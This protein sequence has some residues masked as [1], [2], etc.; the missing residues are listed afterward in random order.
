MMKKIISV[1]LCLW[2]FASCD[3]NKEM[4]Y[5]DFRVSGRVV[6]SET[7]KAIANIQISLRN[8]YLGYFAKTQTDA[9]G[10]FDIEAL[11]GGHIIDSVF[12]VAQDIDSML[13]GYYKSDSISIFLQRDNSGFEQKPASV[14]N[15][16]FQLKRLQ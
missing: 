4:D 12:V 3:I 14:D 8:K 10:T 16:L 5:A 11:N 9:N 13:N 1:I 2:V 7:N 6:E 15:I